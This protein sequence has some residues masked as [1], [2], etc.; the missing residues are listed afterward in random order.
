MTYIPVD[1]IFAAFAMPQDDKWPD[2]YPRPTQDL[3]RL[4]KAME[5]SLKAHVLHIEMLG[6]AVRVEQKQDGPIPAAGH[7][8]PVVT[9]TPKRTRAS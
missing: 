1:A 5:D 6:F 3:L 2:N 8:H 4:K 7:S 9:L